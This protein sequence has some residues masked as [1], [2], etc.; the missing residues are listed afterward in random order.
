M[1]IESSSNSAV[2]SLALAEEEELL[3]EFDDIEY[4]EDDDGE[5]VHEHSEGIANST[6]TSEE[7]LRPWMPR[8]ERVQGRVRDSG[9]EQY[10]AGVIGEYS[11]HTCDK[12]V[13]SQMHPC[14]CKVCPDKPDPPG[15]TTRVL[16]MRCWDGSCFTGRIVCTGQ[17][18]HFVEQEDATVHI[19][20]V[21]GDTV[22]RGGIVPAKTDGVTC[23]RVGQRFIKS[24]HGTVWGAVFIHSGPFRND[25]AHGE[26]DVYDASSKTFLFRAPYFHGERCTSVVVGDRTLLISD[27]TGIFKAAPIEEEEELLHRDSINV[28]GNTY[29]GA[30]SVNSVRANTSFTSLNGTT[31]QGVWEHGQP[32]GRFCITYAAGGAVEATLNGSI[33]HQSDHRVVAPDNHAQNRKRRREPERECMR[34]VVA[35]AFERDGCIFQGASRS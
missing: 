11:M 28:Y 31:Y 4:T 25:K 1:S 10:P 22:Y 20:G 34:N 17:Y 15:T 24:G 18:V 3:A 14:M 26:H 27:E 19:S 23:A 12:N 13:E 5:R 29:G 6:C 33:N 7:P 16:D 32:R 9:E 21:D 35:P 30:A 2:P 8:V